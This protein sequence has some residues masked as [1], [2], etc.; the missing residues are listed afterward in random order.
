MVF[1]G[2]EEGSKIFV[3]LNG[4]PAGSAAAAAMYKQMSAHA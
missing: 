3:E 2:V 1:A 4:E